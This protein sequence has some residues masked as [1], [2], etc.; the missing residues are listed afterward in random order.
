MRQIRT[1]NLVRLTAFILRVGLLLASACG[2]ATPTH[3]VADVPAEASS[4]P[5]VQRDA[6][7]P[8]LPFPD[9]PDPS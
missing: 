8:E 4:M 5:E 2:P 6:D 9:N 1:E 7:V 3:V